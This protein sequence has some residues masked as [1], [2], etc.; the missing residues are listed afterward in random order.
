[1]SIQSATAYRLLDLNFT[2]KEIDRFWSKVSKTPP[3][4]CWL[5]TDKPDKWGYGRFG[6]YR[7]GQPVKMFAHRLAF[8][9]YWRIDPGA[10]LVCHECDT[11]ACCNPA[12][13]F[14]GT[15][16]DNYDDMVRKG[17][18]SFTPRA[19]APVRRRKPRPAKPRPSQSCER[20]RNARLTPEMVASI[21]RAR[22]QEVPRPTARE[23]GIRF[24]ISTGH[25]NKIFN[26]K[27]WQAAGQ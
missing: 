14:S 17:R 22:E 5:W 19:D 10:A 2:D 25:A 6:I 7:N 11:P 24:G 21:R 20:N 15:D 12:C 23:L 8:F 27:H 26:K 1:M 18:R 16:K 9:L 13:L 4:Q 3:D